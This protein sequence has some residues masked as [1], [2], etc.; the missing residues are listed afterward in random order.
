MRGKLANRLRAE[1]VMIDPDTIEDVDDS[2]GEALHAY[3]RDSD[4]GEWRWQWIAV[5]T[6]LEAGRG[7]LVPWLTA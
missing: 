4:T 7:D 5:E 3:G 6:L 1:R 2:D